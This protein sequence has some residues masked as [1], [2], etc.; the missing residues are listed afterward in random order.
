MNKSAMARIIIWSIVAVLS[1][2]ALLF[3]IISNTNSFGFISTYYDNEELYSVCYG[4]VEITEE[5]NKLDINWIDGNISVD[6]HDGDEII[7]NEYGVTDEDSR[8]RYLVR[9]GE[10]I[11]QP[12][13]SARFISDGDIPTKDLVVL[14]PNTMAYLV[15]VEASNIDGEIKLAT[16]E[17][18]R[19]LIESV[20]AEIY[21]S[22]V[23]ANEIDIEVVSADVEAKGSFNDISIESV[24]G[25]VKIT[26]EVCPRELDADTVSGNFVIYIPDTSEFTVELDEVSGSFNSDFA[27]TKRGDSYI[28]GSGGADF[29]IDGVSGDIQVKKIAEQC[30]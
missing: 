18:H 24:S 7:I 17:A 20:S 1:L 28:V 5:I 14:I 19:M 29:T 10:L 8:L 13:K 22:D 3:G 15:N 23:T 2:A 27:Y 16:V 26:S 9:N 11:I 12:R 25:D 30:K 4:K 6:T 21:I